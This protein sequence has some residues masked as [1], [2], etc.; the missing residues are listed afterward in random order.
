MSLHGQKAIFA[1]HEKLEPKL[2]HEH[3]TD[4]KND[5]SENVCSPVIKVV[6]LG[7]TEPLI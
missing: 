5:G 7:G 6:L 3:E 4:V 1:F 2:I